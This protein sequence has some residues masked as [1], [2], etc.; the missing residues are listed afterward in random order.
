MRQVGE[1]IAP[2]GE[3]A[4]SPRSSL[5]FLVVLLLAL[6]AV[7]QYNYP[8]FHMIV[9]GISVI[10]ASALF[11][12]LYHTRRL[13][14]ND[15]LLF[16][17]I[18]LLFFVLLDVPHS[19]GFRGVSMFPG[20]DSN[21]PTQAY[22]AQ[23]LMLS[24]TFVIAPLFLTRRLWVRTAFIAFGVLTVLAFMSLLV[25]RN[26]PDMFVEGQGLT[27]LKRQLEFLISGMFLVGGIG[28]IAN[29]RYFDPRVLR[30]LLASLVFFV[31][32]EF[33]FTLYSEPFGFAN[34][35]GHLF[36]V[37]AFYLTYRA[38]LVTALANP[39]G[40]LFR[41]L[42]A[43]EQSLTEVNESLNAV[44]DISDAAISSLDIS[45]LAPA[46]LTRLMRVM[47]ADAAALLLAEDGSLRMV[48]S[49]G[50]SVETFAVPVG[51]G[52]SGRMAV[53]R[54][55]RYV[56]DLQEGAE[57]L[58]RPLRD[59]GIRSIL[60]VPMLV[61]DRLIGTLHVDWRTRHAYDERDLRLL[62]I[63][64]DRIALALRN[65][66]LY[67]GERRIAQMFQESLL[68]LPEHINGIKYAKSYHSATEEAWVGGDF[69]DLFPVDPHRVGVLIGDVSGKGI[70]AA[71]LTSIVKDT[72]RAHVHEGAP[73]AV[74]LRKTNA[75]LEHYSGSETFVT[76]F[77][78]VLERS[79][80]RFTYCNAGHLPAIS[81][82]CD[83]ELLL[84]PS[85]SPLLGAFP[86]VEFEDDE[87][88]LA[89][90]QTLFLYTDG[91]I[92]ARSGHELYGEERLFSTLREQRDCDPEEMIDA[93]LED[94]LTFSGGSLTDDLAILALKVVPD[95]E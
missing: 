42:S 40:L 28:L 26:F 53:D 34:F 24:A 8:L 14:D 49:V 45:Q 75:L 69:F 89:P 6:V 70:E 29:R 91:V 25:W 55:P 56:E 62:E 17:G 37:S 68:S 10:V 80:G 5:T 32:S 87:V 63:V 31:G 78:G 48:A 95:D 3:V 9:E 21:L 84:L 46:L 54:K 88:L 38:V 94:L 59:Q 52:F 58:S 43:R 93:A 33:A 20:F 19:L 67:Q 92:E 12:V 1:P 30:L 60:G 35:A 66:Q 50:Y 61:G 44:A 86:D 83:G 16:V 79:T 51:E 71:V 27:P 36:Q 23:R 47:H 73:P 90:G 18:S 7:S 2:S 13:Q 64:G 57:V 74:V 65:A 22:I 81:T 11:L 76:V 72:I 85:N 77:F 41:E 4:G 82:A 15:Y 39:F